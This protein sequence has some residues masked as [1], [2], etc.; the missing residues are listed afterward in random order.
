MVVDMDF[1]VVEYLVN[2]KALSYFPDH[3]AFPAACDPVFSL[4]P[5]N[6]MP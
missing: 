4:I 2:V 3:P 5:E 1:M 6:S